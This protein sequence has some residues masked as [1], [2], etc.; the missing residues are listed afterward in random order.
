MVIC[1][2]RKFVGKTK[3]VKTGKMNKKKRACE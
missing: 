3:T 1:S 2:Y